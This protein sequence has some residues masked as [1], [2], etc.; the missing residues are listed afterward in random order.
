MGV[1]QRCIDEGITPSAV[2]VPVRG[3]IELNRQDRRAGLGVTQHE[4]QVLGYDSVE[5]TLTISRSGRDPNQVRHPDLPCD[6]IPGTDNIAEYTPEGAFGGGQ[7][8]IPPF[9]GKLTI[10]SQH[11]GNYCGNNQGCCGNNDDD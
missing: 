4:I 5:V 6:M 8:V 10:A 3:I 9:V 11:S 7:Q 1:S 2:A